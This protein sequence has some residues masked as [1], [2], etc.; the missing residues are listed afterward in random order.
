MNN[1]SSLSDWVTSAARQLLDAG[2]ASARL[3]AELILTHTIRKNRTYLHAHGDEDLSDR[4]KEIADARLLLRLDRTPLAYII[5]HKEFYGRR[6]QVTPATLIPRPESEAIITL[7]Q[8]ALRQTKLPLV[9]KN[10]NLV[11]VGTGSGC[12]GITAKLEFPE[13][14]VTLLDTSRHALTVAAENAKRLEADVTI[15]RSDLLQDYP[16]TADIIL[17]N[18]PY[19]GEDW[20]V[21][22]ETHYEPHEA[23]YAADDGLALINHLLDAAPH[24]L[25]AGGML[26]IEAD[27][28]QHD[29]IIAYALQRGLQHTAT[30]GFIIWLERA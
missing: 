11:D 10:P 7:L 24:R 19:V 29:A 22:P 17:A 6:F 9:S 4:H 28:R 15:L 20:D 26:F 27:P 16:L 21:S 12:L 5:G 1:K 30:E 8:K 3:D 23:L 14:D 25:V 13:L 18:L 2:T